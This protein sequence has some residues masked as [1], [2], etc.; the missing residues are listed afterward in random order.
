MLLK[1]LLIALC[2]SQTTAWGTLYYALPVTSGQIAADTGWSVLSIMSAFSA[3][4]VLS[5]AAGIPAGRLLDRYGARLVMTVGSLVGVAGL[6]LV[7]TAPSL[8]WFVVAWVVA[9]LAQ[10][11]TLYQAA[12]TVIN[13]TFGRRRGTALTV[14][15]LA[16]GLASTI[17]API[18]ASL[19]GALGWRGAFLILAG[20]LAV[21]VVPL[22]ALT[23]PSRWPDASSRSHPAD[24]VTLRRIVGSRP[25]LMLQAGLTLVSLGLYAATLNLVP[26]L[27]DRG[28]TPAFAALVFGL[29]GVGQVAGRLLFLT[30]R[31]GAHAT[32][33]S[34]IVAAAAT[35]VLALLAV[36]TGP[37]AVLVVLAVLAGAVRGSLTLVQAS[38]V[39]ER[40][41]TARL[42]LL[43]GIFTAPITAATAVAPAVGVGL[44]ILVGSYPAA[45][46]VV[47]GVCGLGTVAAALS[48]LPKAG[49]FGESCQDAR[50]G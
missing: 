44:A 20:I 38:A 4:L 15:T 48:R 21:V 11:V 27:T 22:N 42:G 2:V 34:V 49:V 35:L 45:L 5:A 10:A 30:G 9:G 1:L 36:T 26:I 18:A 40:W 19:T 39:A 8:A 47:A 7:A 12:F 50:A 33:T 25:F 14:L 6:V 24:A 13:R 37:A 17:F 43:N 16:A 32:L 28:Y 46:L 31:P 29:V 23:L 3:G 41:G